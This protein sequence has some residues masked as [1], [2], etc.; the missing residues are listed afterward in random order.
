MDVNSTSFFTHDANKNVMQKTNL[1]GIVDMK[2][3]YHPFGEQLVSNAE[4][5]NFSSETAD[6]LLKM[7][8]Y[9]FR[10]YIPM[11]SR[12]NNRDVLEE[13]GGKNIYA[14]LSNSPVSSFDCLGLIDIPKE[15]YVPSPFVVIGHHYWYGNWGGPGWAGGQPVTDGWMDPRLIGWKKDG[16]LVYLPIDQRE[17]PLDELDKCYKIHDECYENCRMPFR[18]IIVDGNG[19][20]IDVIEGCPSQTA[21]CFNQC[22][23]D[24]VPCQLK[25]LGHLIETS[26]YAIHNSLIQL[27]RYPIR[28]IG[29]V[30]GVL[31][32]G[33]QGHRRQYVDPTID[34]ARQHGEWSIVISPPDNGE[35][36]GYI[37]I[38]F[39]ISW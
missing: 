5:M 32:L 26:N 14:F 17:K 27:I 6:S 18:R 19:N 20:I 3:A 22:D 2:N 39:K 35:E 9:N 37:G 21:P 1:D 13:T 16:H 25:A 28:A 30:G 34:W 24:S 23:F 11:L 38:G 4:N 7:V 8:Y 31:A 15:V 33:G 29:V 10:Y 12:W 36:K